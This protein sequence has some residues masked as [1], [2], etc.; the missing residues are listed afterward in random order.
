[1]NET[2][3]VVVAGAGPVG[4]MLACELRL[5]GVDVLVVERLPELDRTI[6]A[7]AINV[8]T[9]QAF[10]RRGLLPELLA[11]QQVAIEAIR[12]F[13]GPSTIP[14]DR[15]P[16]AGHF[17]G[18]MLPFDVIDGDDPD[19]AGVGPAA[20]T[21]LVNQQGIE[22]I[23]GARAAELGVVVRRGLELTGLTDDGKGVTVHCGAESMRAAWLVG[24]DGGRSVVRKL[25]GFDFP[26]IDPEI[27]GRQAVVEMSD[28]EGLQLGWN[29][30]DNGIYVYGP[31]PGRFLTVE[32]DG[33]PAER[34]APVTAAELEA[35]LRRVT[36]VPVRITAVHSATRFTDNTRQVSDYRKGRVLLAGDAAHV[37]SPFGGQGLNLGIGDAVDLGWKLG[38]VV[39]GRMGEELLDTYTA[40]RYPIGAWVL[41]WTRAQV[42]LMR[43]DR[44]SKALREVMAE[45]LSTGDGATAVLKRISGVLHRYNLGGGHRLVGAVV[46]DLALSDGSRVAEHFGSGAGVLFDLTDSAELRA[47]AA[48]WRDRIRTVTAKPLDSPS[49]PDLAAILVRPDGYVAWAADEGGVV[50]D[51]PDLTAALR[52]WF[53]A[54]AQVP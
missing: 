45:L 1:M 7:G 51:L 2:F 52:R 47:A 18:I 3:D 9:A 41:E 12:A 36:G 44:R 26:G 29:D 42:A 33:P 16:I 50:R 13:A 35:S 40:E 23:L 34:D 53:G 19:F 37:H 8:P 27:T 31:T 46:P 11:R 48:G 22:E 32:L 30:T 21:M 10:D 4:L 49:F 17:A 20:L 54:P 14:A 43:L 15:P 6:K 24:C 38:A 25:A 5:A 39:A 28:T